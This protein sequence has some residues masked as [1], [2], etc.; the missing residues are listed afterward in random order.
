MAG[1][2][3]LLVCNFPSKKKMVQVPKPFKLWIDEKLA[4]FG[5]DV[6]IVDVLFNRIDKTLQILCGDDIS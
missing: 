2:L 6:T 3:V 4:H 1:S 5:V